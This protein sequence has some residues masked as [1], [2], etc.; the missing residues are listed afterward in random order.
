MFGLT[1]R[2]RERER[3]MRCVLFDREDVWCFEWQR[4]V[5]FWLSREVMFWMQREVMCFV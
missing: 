2:E 3:E 5:K 4:Q 1:E